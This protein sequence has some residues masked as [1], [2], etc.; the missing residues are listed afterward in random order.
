MKMED[1][2]PEARLVAADS[3]QD[4]AETGSVLDYLWEGQEGSAFE[5]VADVAVSDSPGAV[6]YG[7]AANDA[8]DNA[9]EPDVPS[10][11][12]ALRSY[13][14]WLSSIQGN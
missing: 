13:S 9:Q 11:D 3:K 6:E 1:D 2:V 7:T 14:S 5:P 4:V 8:E 10:L 12:L